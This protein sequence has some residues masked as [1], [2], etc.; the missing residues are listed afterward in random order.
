VQ[1]LDTT[2]RAFFSLADDDK[3]NARM[4]CPY[5]GKFW[6]WAREQQQQLLPRE[7]FMVRKETEKYTAQLPWNVAPRRF[8][9]ET[10]AMYPIQPPP[11]PTLSA[12][13]I[14]MDHR[15]PSR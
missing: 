13:S 4:K 9:Q 5:T 8:Q 10:R 7:Y 3:E 12:G 14:R 15:Y 11:R 2:A 1:V 6:G